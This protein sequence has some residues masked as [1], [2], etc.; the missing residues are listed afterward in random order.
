LLGVNKKIKWTVNG[1]NI[2]VLIPKD[3]SGKNELSYAAVFKI[4]Y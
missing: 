4:Q 1:D 3:I 2:K